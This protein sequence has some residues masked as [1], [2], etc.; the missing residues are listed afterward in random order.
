MKPKGAVTSLFTNALDIARH[1]KSFCR[2]NDH[3]QKQQLLRHVNILYRIKYHW[4]CLIQ[5]QPS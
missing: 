1:I 5:K 4:Q 3:K 2:L